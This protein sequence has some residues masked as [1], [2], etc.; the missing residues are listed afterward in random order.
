MTTFFRRSP[1]LG[2][3]ICVISILLFIFSANRCAYY[4]TE[5]KASVAE[6][7]SL[8]TTIEKQLSSIEDMKLEIE[9]KNKTIEDML[10]KTS[11]T[12]PSKQDFKSYMSYTAITNTSSAQYK[13]Q[14][15]ATT[16][17]NGIRC[18]NSKPMV[19]V[20][21][22]WGVS[23][24][25]IVLMVCDNGNSFEAVIGDIK[26][27]AHTNADNKT[28]SSNGCRCEFIVDVGQLNKDVKLM[29]NVSVLEKYTGY[30]I[31]IEKLN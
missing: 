30:V 19:A 8:K 18:I 5:Y 11:I 1:L 14:Q 24:G 15:Q 26:A 4:K 7:H 29:G 13:L 23:V 6:N 12:Q 28:T 2:S 17:E 25:D 16:D 9:E 20:G 22:G 3:V 31:S 10:K 21:T 27:N